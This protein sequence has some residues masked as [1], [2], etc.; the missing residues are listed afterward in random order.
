MNDAPRKVPHVEQ[1]FSDQAGSGKTIKVT[2]NDL[3]HFPSYLAT[4]LHHPKMALRI[5]QFVRQPD[6][7]T[8]RQ[9]V[10]PPSVETP[11]SKDTFPFVKIDL[12]IQVS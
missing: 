1:F 10:V 8:A 9:H 3:R 6:Q 5:D 11:G 4:S 2:S 12:H 7:R